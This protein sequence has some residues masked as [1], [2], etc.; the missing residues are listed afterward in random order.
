MILCLER[1]ME[2]GE[3]VDDAA[4]RPDVALL[5]VLHIIDLLWAHVVRGANMRVGKLA[6]LIHNSRQTEIPNFDI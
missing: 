4:E 2:G 3:L 6:F 1:R 5:V